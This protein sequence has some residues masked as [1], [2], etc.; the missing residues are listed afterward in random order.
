MGAGDRRMGNSREGAG[1][2]GARALRNRRPS[3]HSL[4]TGWP[5]PATW[6][7]EHRRTGGGD[8]GDEPVD[9]HNRGRGVRRGVWEWVLGP[10]ELDTGE[11][12]GRGWAG[13]QM[14]TMQVA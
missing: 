11:V 5:R 1:V 3:A 12:A 14:S 6:V 9:C 4:C 10:G 7:K 8:V 2:V 13:R